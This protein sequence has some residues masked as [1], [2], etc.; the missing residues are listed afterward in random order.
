MPVENVWLITGANRGIGL[1]MTKQLLEQPSNTVIATA[2]DPA[3]AT[4]LHALKSS[5][6]GTLHIVSL[7]VADRE[8][9]RKCADEVAGI[10]GDKGI[11]YLV[12]N[13]GILISEGHKDTAY[14]MDIDVL[15]RVLKTN[16][17][18]PAY[19]SQVLLPL[20]GKSAKKTIVNVSSTLG[21]KAW[22]GPGEVRSTS[23]SISKAA[24]NMLTVK[25]AR[26]RP[27]I[28]SVSICPGWLQTDMGGEGAMH[29]V[30]VGVAGILKVVNGLTP[31]NSGEFLN[32]EGERVAW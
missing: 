1:E 3:K 5:A 9:I 4:E 15:E 25:Q 27:D 22:K 30:S 8:S 14:V 11:D 28:T 12:N 7:D 18:G 2:R 26:E 20:I 21:S 19:T 31:A 16:V 6:K 24:L 10:L 17:S 23:Y 32:F 13:A 29:P